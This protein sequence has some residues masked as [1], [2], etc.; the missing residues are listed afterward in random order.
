MYIIDLVVNFDIL[1]TIFILF[2]AITIIVLGVLYFIS[3]RDSKIGEAIL[4]FI[5]AIID[6]FLTFGKMPFFIITILFLILYVVFL[7]IITIIPETGFQTLFI[8][9]REMLLSIPPLPALIDRGV[10]NFFKNVFKLFGF[11]QDKMSKRLRIFFSEYML[12]SKDNIIEMIAVFNP[13]IKRD[14][15]DTLIETMANKNKGEANIKKDVDICV[16]NSSTFTTPD[17]GMIDEFKTSMNNIK[18]NI[19]CNMKSIKPYVLQNI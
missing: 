1:Y 4:K 19:S 11:S 8:P 7:I 12:F 17:M 14:S 10:F 6:K 3:N 18:N 15:L 13:S 9:V 5:K 16:N 2:W